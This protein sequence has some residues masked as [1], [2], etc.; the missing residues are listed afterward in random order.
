MNRCEVGDCRTVL[1][2]LDAGIFS[3]CVTSPPY[4]GLRNYGCDAQIGLEPTPA[5]YVEELVGVFRHV[6]R[7][8]RDDATLWLNLG[9]SYRKKQLLGIPW[10]VALA[11]Q[12]DGWILRSD[13]IW[14]KPDCVPDPVRDRP[15][16]A[17]EHLFL[18]AKQPKYLCDMQQ[19]RE[20]AVSSA[21]P[22]PASAQRGTKALRIGQL[23]SGTNGNVGGNLGWRR[24]ELGRNSRSVWSITRS[25]AR[26][27]PGHSA[28]M[29][30]ELAR[31]CIL[32]GSELGGI[33]LDPFYGSGTTGAVAERL[34]RHWFGC[35]LNPAFTADAA[36][37]S[38]R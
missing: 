4:Y 17:H 3:C 5:Q 7:V 29:P 8:L 10:R 35:E 27:S 34:G 22:R 31:R 20:A 32:A 28:V 18:L 1:P 38:A 13:I 25:S 24:P 11:L 15:T 9:D 21:D 23:P 6:R 2:T 12:S 14:N 30:G 37:G 16:L 26:K 33:V 36:A 19:L